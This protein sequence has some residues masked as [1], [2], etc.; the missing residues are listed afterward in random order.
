MKQ[1]QMNW[2]LR[3]GQRLIGCTLFPKKLM[4]KRESMTRNCLPEGLMTDKTSHEPEGSCYETLGEGL[5]M[6]MWSWMFCYREEGLALTRTCQL[7]TTVGA[8]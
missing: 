3:R 4:I 8:A 5:F 7:T 1:G 6:Q 2:K